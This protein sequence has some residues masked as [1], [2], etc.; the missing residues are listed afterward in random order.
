L[1]A[2]IPPLAEQFKRDPLEVSFVY[3]PYP[4]RPIINEINNLAIDIPLLLLCIISGIGLFIHKK[5]AWF[6]AFGLF[7]LVFAVHVAASISLGEDV[8]GKGITGSFDASYGRYASIAISLVSFYLLARN[9]VRIYLH[10]APE[11]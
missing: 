5:W 4:P 11:K 1:I 8:T 10:L 7:S 3:P 9:D 2:V 6:S